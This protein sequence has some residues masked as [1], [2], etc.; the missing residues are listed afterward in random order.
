[1]KKLFALLAVGLVMFTTVIDNAEAARRLGG[2]MSLGRQAPALR[3]ATPAPQTPALRQNQANRQNAAQPQ[4]NAA[5]ANAASAAKPSMM[6]NILMTAAAALGITALLSA[7]GLSEGLGQIIM[8]VLL[9]A[10]LFFVLRKVLGMFATRSAGG[11]P[12]AASSPSFSRQEPEQ[13]SYSQAQEPQ[14]RTAASVMP[15]TMGA[16]PG[17]VMDLFAR[18]GGTEQQTQ[19]NAE[20]GIPA[21]FDA[22][23]FERVAKENFA[24]LQRAW[25]TGD[26]NSLGDFTTDA[27]FIELTHRLRERGGVK[28]SSEIIQLDAKLEGV[29]KMADAPEHIAVVHFSG[30]MKIE[31]EFEEVNE[32]WV[33]TC[34]DD[35]TSGWLLAGIEQVN[36]Q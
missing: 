12:Q 1:M 5:A 16:Q 19:D 24:R 23:G 7:L 25:D 18:Q 29:A 30:A 36:E 11:R 17:S 13:N 22:A 15:Q 6:R 21:G 32:R 35:N 26:Y 3:Q 34:K 2:G 10:I 9:A 27:L 28:Q 14:S 31:G 8:V 4:K 33:L 20:F